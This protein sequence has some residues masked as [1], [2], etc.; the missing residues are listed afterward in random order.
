M[1]THKVLSLPVDHRISWR[2]VRLWGESLFTWVSGD[3]PADF[4]SQSLAGANLHAPLAKFQSANRA[5]SGIPCPSAIA[6]WIYFPITSAGAYK[7]QGPIKAT[8]YYDLFAAMR[9]A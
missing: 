5:W 8:T 3:G 9:V 6:H 7:Q 1:V 4:S 2:P